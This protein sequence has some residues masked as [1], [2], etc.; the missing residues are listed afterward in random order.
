MLKISITLGSLVLALALSSGCKKKA[1]HSE[2]PAE[3]A[4]EEV[5][6][7]TEE[8]G[9]KIEEAGENIEEKTD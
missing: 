1:E 7:A 9:D 4:G 6:Q 5:D 2:G 3:A 8:A